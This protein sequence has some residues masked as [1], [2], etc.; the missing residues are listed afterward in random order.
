MS[1][2]NI[3]CEHELYIVLSNIILRYMNVVPNEEILQKDC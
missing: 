2:N 1:S 3:F